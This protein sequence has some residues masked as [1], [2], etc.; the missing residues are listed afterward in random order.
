MGFFNRMTY[1]AATLANDVSSVSN[2]RGGIYKRKKE[3]VSTPMVKEITHAV[4]QDNYP[5]KKIIIT[6]NGIISMVHDMES[7]TYHPNGVLV[8]S[9]D[10]LFDYEFACALLL[11]FQD[12]Y[13]NAYEICKR[14]VSEIEPYIENGTWDIYI[15]LKDEYMHKEL[16]PAFS[17]DD[18]GN[19]PISELPIKMNDDL[20]EKTQKLP[21]FS[22]VLGMVSVVSVFVPIL[23]LFHVLASIAGIVTGMIGIGVM[24]KGKRKKAGWGLA[25]SLLSWPLF[26]I[27][28]IAKF[29]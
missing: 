2:L 12:L 17:I 26:I 8:Y 13:P 19:V 23:S 28:T 29:F 21:N 4:F 10:V 15:D 25:L 9:T 27:V 24:P 6:A 7:N 18:V 22:F 1:T 5:P 16:L 20:V 11:I 14:T 3:I